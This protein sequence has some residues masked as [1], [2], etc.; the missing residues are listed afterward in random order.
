MARDRRVLVFFSRS[1][2]GPICSVHRLARVGGQS[3]AASLGGTRIRRLG[4][5][6]ARTNPPSLPTSL[7]SWWSP[8][9][10]SGRPDGPDWR[11][12]PF[13]QPLRLQRTRSLCRFLPILLVLLAEV[14]LLRP[15]RAAQAKP[16][17]GQGVQEC[18]APGWQHWLVEFVE[19]SLPEIELLAWISLQDLLFGVLVLR[20][21]PAEQRGQPCAC[22][23][24]GSL[25]FDFDPPRARRSPCLSPWTPLLKIRRSAFVS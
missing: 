7:S 4:C 23:Q 24:V 14:Q 17:V 20:L 3:V 5:A 13:L 21:G 6:P 16:P 1:L 18:F 9:V 11:R 19:L 12:L 22:S 2:R 10:R 25:K 15:L 8:S